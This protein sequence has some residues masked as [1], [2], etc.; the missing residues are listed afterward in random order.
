[1][2]YKISQEHCLNCSNNKR[3]EPLGR[4]LLSEGVITKELPIKSALKNSYLD[5]AC[6]N[7]DIFFLYRK[8]IY[9]ESKV[10]Y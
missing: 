8:L 6:C 1:M 9:I 10:I 2:K 5:E 4:A 3:T 7:F